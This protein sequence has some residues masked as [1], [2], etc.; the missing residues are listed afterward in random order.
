MQVPLGIYTHIVGTDLIRDEQGS[1]WCWK[2]ICAR[3]AACPTCSPTAPA[4]TRIYP[5]MFEAQGVR[6]VQHYATAL[7]ERPE[8]LSPR[9]PDATVVV[10]TPGMYNSAYFEHAYLAQQM[11]VALVEGRDL[12]VDDGRV[13][14]RTT[15]GRTQV[16]VIYR[17]IDDDFLDPLTFRRDSLAGRAGSGRGLP[18]GPRG[19]C[20]RH[21]HRVADDKAVYAYVPEMIEY[22]LNENADPGQRADLPRLECRPPGR[23]CSTTPANWW[24][25][26]WA[27]RAATAC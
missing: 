13:C 10:L 6:P 26:R 15:A 5:G 1:I 2:T 11:G 27:R 7:L 12:F 18:P 19:A 14:M 17:R 8:S 25:R 9:A 24:S 22:Y 20:Q 3:P 21:R 23:T 16:D 4:M